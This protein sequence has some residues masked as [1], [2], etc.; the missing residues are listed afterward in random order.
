M[1]SVDIVSHSA[2][3]TII[4]HRPNSP[5]S[6]AEVLFIPASLPPADP[7]FLPDFSPSLGG[8]RPFDP[9]T[10]STLPADC[11]LRTTK[12]ELRTTPLTHPTQTTPPI[13]RYSPIKPQIRAGRAGRC[14]HFTHDN[15][16]PLDSLNLQP[17]RPVAVP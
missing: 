4:L 16:Y 14:S 9:S 8:E 15:P 6:R 11:D 17:N 13:S 3:T 12:Y 1:V 10:P 7:Y 2:G 5:T